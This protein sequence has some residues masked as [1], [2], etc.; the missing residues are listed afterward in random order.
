MAMTW[1]QTLYFARVKMNVVPLALKAPIM[2]QSINSVV[3]VKVVSEPT[4]FPL[5]VSLRKEK[6]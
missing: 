2:D 6:G 1:Q 3:Y 4:Q 5:S